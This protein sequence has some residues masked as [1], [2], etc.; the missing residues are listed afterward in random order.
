[1]LCVCKA[2]SEVIFSPSFLPLKSLVQEWVLS[3]VDSKQTSKHFHNW[4]SQYT[5]RMGLYWN[6]HSCFMIP[7]H[8]VYTYVHQAHLL[9]YVHLICHTWY[10]LAVPASQPAC[11]AR[12]IPHYVPLCPTYVELQYVQALSVDIWSGMAE[13]SCIVEG[14]Q[15]GA[16]AD[17]HTALSRVNQKLL[18][19][20][21]Y[22]LQGFEGVWWWAI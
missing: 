15:C 11:H 22:L 5:L 7:T 16:V 21:Y 10:W 6:V 1:M 18:I 8:V 4:S 19:C 17:R 9:P 3:S 12:C 14:R 20:V 13:T 2:E